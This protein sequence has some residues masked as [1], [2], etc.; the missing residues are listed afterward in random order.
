MTLAHEALAT[1][2]PP[3]AD[4]GYRSLI[5]HVASGVEAGPRLR[6]AAGLARRLD[7]TLIGVGAEMVRPM[8]TGSS[9]GMFGGDMIV[10]LTRLAQDNI[11][12]AETAFRAETA[13]LK[14]QWT[15]VLDMP[16]KAVARYARAADLIIAGGAPIGKGDGFIA[17]DT[18]ELVMQSGRPVLI[19]PPRG[20]SLHADAVVVAWKD[21]R[22]ARRALAD[23]LPLLKMAE[24][25][26]VLE[27]CEPNL[28][29]DAQVHTAAVAEHLRR[30]GVSAQS[31]AVAAE[32]DEPASI[33]NRQAAEIGADLIV[34]GGYGHSRLGEWMFGGVTRD[35]LLRPERFVLMS[36]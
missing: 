3:S 21:S 26:L 32:Q 22:E 11:Q 8:D 27:V 20:G 24:E 6:V 23:S 17:A 16:A 33:L 19:A 18:A 7:A 31:K 35:L 13:G 28:V 2:R 34:A 4:V 15:A 29:A 1:R 25:V 9:Y 36:H 10:E 12:R 5:V 14:A 30:H